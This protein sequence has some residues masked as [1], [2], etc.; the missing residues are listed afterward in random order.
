MG[1]RLRA[2]PANGHLESPPSSLCAETERQEGTLPPLSLPTLRLGSGL[3]VGSRKGLRRGVLRFFG[4][5]S[6]GPGSWSEGEEG[7]PGPTLR[8]RDILE[9]L[10]GFKEAKSLGLSHIHVRLKGKDSQ[11]LLI[12]L[13][14]AEL[15]VQGSLALWGN[16]HIQYSDSTEARAPPRKP[17]PQPSPA[18]PTKSPKLLACL[19]HAPEGP[20]S[21]HQHS[22]QLQMQR[23]MGGRGALSV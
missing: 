8:A 10:P 21:W 9:C 7:T 6:T 23:G 16:K 20:Q 22:L 13:S 5:I 1:T 18:A 19:L 4:V 17:R 12:S 3:G 11:P 14:L 15:C 2:H